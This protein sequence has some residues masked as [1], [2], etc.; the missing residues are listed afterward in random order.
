MGIFG[1]GVT[2]EIVLCQECTVE[3]LDDYIET[4]EVKNVF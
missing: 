3:L 1:D 2:V 4:V